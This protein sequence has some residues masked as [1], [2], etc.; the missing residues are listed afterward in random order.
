[1]RYKLFLNEISVMIV[2]NIA[3][4]ESIQ[5]LNSYFKIRSKNIKQSWTE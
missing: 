1:M 5:K 2:Q 3:D 4:A